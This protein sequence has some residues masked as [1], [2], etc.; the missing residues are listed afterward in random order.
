MWFE[1]SIV[2]NFSFVC[3]LA[4]NPLYAFIVCLSNPFLQLPSA[5]LRSVDVG[6]FECELEDEAGMWSTP[7][8]LADRGTL[9]QLRGL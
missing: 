8:S 6:L 3:F 2:F 1:I 5:P 9:I 7:F 4:M